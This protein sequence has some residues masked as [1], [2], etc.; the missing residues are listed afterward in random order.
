MKRSS[1]SLLSQTKKESFELRFNS[2]RGCMEI[3]VS[4]H[5]EMYP[6]ILK[7]Q[8]TEKL[9]CIKKAGKGLTMSEV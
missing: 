3:F 6:F 5:E 1:H 8:E 4:D 9:Y 7:D 2:N